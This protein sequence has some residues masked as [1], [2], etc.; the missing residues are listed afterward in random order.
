[1]PSANLRDT[2]TWTGEAAFKAAVLNKLRQLSRVSPR[3]RIA[4]E[5]VFGS[6]GVRA[7]LAI[8][9]KELTGVEIKTDRDS[10][11]RLGRQMEAYRLHCHKVILAIAPNHLV[12]A[13]QVV[14]NDVEIW[15]VRYGKVETIRACKSVRATLP[16]T[17]TLLTQVERTKIGFTPQHGVLTEPNQVRKTVSILASRYEKTSEQFWSDV[18]G[19]AIVSEDISTL[20]RFKSVRELAAKNQAATKA[21]WDSWESQAAL[22]F[23]PRV[24]AIAA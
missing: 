3:S 24:E 11:K 18:K 14:P 10:L 7:D 13:S 21:E 17:W 23:G 8:F 15:T 20:S 16:E 22:I 2:P 1:M 19:R 9:G 6:T 12:A 5:F 4:N